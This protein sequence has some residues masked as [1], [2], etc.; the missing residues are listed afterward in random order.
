MHAS[1]SMTWQMDPTFTESGK[2]CRGYRADLST[3][4]GFWREERSGVKVLEKPVTIPSGK[5]EYQGYVIV[6]AYSSKEDVRRSSDLSRS[7]SERRRG[8][9]SGD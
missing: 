3:N 8:K 2:A 7:D 6:Y 5:T 9:T 1:S 4:V